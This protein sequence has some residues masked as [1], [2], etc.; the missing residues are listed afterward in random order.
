MDKN[1]FAD[2]IFVAGRMSKRLK[3]KGISDSKNSALASAELVRWNKMQG[4]GCVWKN[5]N[6]AY[7]E[8]ASPQTKVRI[9]QTKYAESANEGT[10]ASIFKAYIQPNKGWHPVGDKK[11][12]KNGKCLCARRKC[13]NL[14][15]KLNF[16]RGEMTQSIFGKWTNEP[17]RENRAAYEMFKCLGQKVAGT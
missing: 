16:W 11:F 15:R 10:S 2:G 5:C 6:A 8:S 17:V 4:G 14:L 7:G 13:R 9:R 12:L 3:K 1:F